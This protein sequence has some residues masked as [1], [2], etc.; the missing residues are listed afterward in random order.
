MTGHTHV[1][2]FIVETSFGKPT[3]LT[4]KLEILVGKNQGAG[5]G[6]LQ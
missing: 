6:R 3:Y 4:G 5:R 2:L 1:R